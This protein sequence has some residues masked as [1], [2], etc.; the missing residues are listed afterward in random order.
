MSR[1]T[2]YR[3]TTG[4]TLV[5]LLVVIGIIA[6]LIGILLPALQRAYSAAQA[7]ACASNMRQIDMAITA[8]SQANNG[9]L[10]MPP[11]KAQNTADPA[12]TLRF[13][14][15]NAFYLQADSNANSIY[16]M[17]DF[18]H[19]V[20]SPYISKDPN[21]VQRIFW[22]PADQQQSTVTQSSS[23]GGYVHNFSYSFNFNINGRETDGQPNA[24][25]VRL[26]QIRDSTNKILVFEERAPNDGMCYCNPSGPGVGGNGTFDSNDLP[27]TRH[28]K[29]AKTPINVPTNGGVKVLTGGKCNVA[30][31]DGHVELIDGYHE[32][33]T[34]S[35]YCDLP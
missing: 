10:P 1:H 7:V 8:Y 25:W 2:L 13:Y 21:A 30:F 15:Y 4:F 24:K 17:A 29:G 19:G 27:G 12:W 23:V 31:A 6:L 14:P 11:D 5:E 35:Q 3:R 9:Y 16:G 20:L 26:V 18:S 33:W 28:G 22:C 34:Y 32:K